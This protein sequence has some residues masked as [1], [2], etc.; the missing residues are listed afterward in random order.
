MIKD[1]DSV[2][3]ACTPIDPIFKLTRFYITFKGE[4]TFQKDFPR[5]E[6]FS[7]D[8]MRSTILRMRSAENFPF[9]GKS[10]E[11]GENCNMF[12]VHTNIPTNF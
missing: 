10:S 1:D 12:F 8:R 7:G 2:Q 9:R 6:K 5:N 11:D 4:Y 3:T